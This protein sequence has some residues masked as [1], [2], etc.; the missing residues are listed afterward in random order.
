V[1]GRSV[2][3]V[4][5]SVQKHHEYGYHAKEGRA[6]ESAVSRGF[7]LRSRKARILP[8]FMLVSSDSAV[9]IQGCAPRLLC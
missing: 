5:P 3:G 8:V 4:P 1:M 6:R 7:A 9:P 2:T